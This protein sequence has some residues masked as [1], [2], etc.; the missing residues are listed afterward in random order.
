[1]IRWVVL[2]MLA[3]TTVALADNDEP[4]ETSDGNAPLVSTGAATLLDDKA[5]WRWDI[6][7]APRLAP[8]IGALAVSGLDAVSG[9]GKAIDAL[10]EP[11]APPAAWPYDVKGTAKAIP[12]PAD[13]QRIAAAFGVATFELTAQQQG[14]EVRRFGGRFFLPAVLFPL[15]SFPFIS[16]SSG[17]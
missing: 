5:A 10:G 8:Q 16:L 11:V 1:M 4:A 17:S 9:R 14:L 12:A 2:G 15:Y 7:T 6:V 13:D 3:T